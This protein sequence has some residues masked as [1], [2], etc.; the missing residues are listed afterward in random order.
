MSNPQLENGFT[1][2]ANEILEAL[3]RTNLSPYEWRVLMFLFR[4]TYGHQKKADAIPRS[5]FSNGLCLDRRLVH[6]AIKS[7]ESK[8]LLVIS[9]DDSGA[10][11]YQFQ[12]DYTKWRVSSRKMTVI[13]REDKLS[14][15]EMTEVSSP[16]MPSKERRKEKRNVGTGKPSPNPLSSTVERTIHRLNELSGKSYRPESKA[17]NQYL[18]ARLKDGVAE[19][20]VLAVVEDRW[21]RWGNHE[22]M[23][24]HFNPV[25]LF[26]P[27]KFEKYLTEAKANGSEPQNPEDLEALA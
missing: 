12:K 9:R 10:V 27:S 22:K 7:L 15:A 21:R 20:D 26:R 24:E 16:E 1:R 2:I 5:Q 6:R 23:R 8:R 19:D 11:S 25:T 18:L 14:S 4:K 3:A 13:S 17:V